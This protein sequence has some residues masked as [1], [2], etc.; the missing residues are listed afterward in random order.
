M[1]VESGRREGREPNG[2]NKILNKDFEK[3]ITK[4]SIEQQW[5]VKRITCL[6]EKSRLHG[7]TVLFPNLD[8]HPRTCIPIKHRSSSF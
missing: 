1:V 4:T 2:L 3:I 7:L 6:Q 5:S 8:I